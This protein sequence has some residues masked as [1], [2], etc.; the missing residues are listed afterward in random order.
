MHHFEQRLVL[1]QL[2]QNLSVSLKPQ[3]LDVWASGR[4][5]QRLDM[6]IWHLVVLFSI[7]P[8]YSASRRENLASRCFIQHLVVLFSIWTKELG[9]WPISLSKTENLASRRLPT[10][11]LFRPPSLLVLLSY[12]MSLFVA[13]SLSH[14][15]SSISFFSTVSCRVRCFCLVSF[16]SCLLP[17]NS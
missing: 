3:H 6:R 10:S 8:F 12:S 16:P 7:W 17:L 15:L 4:F 5:I 2:D 14:S 9:I 1:E 11:C 13:F